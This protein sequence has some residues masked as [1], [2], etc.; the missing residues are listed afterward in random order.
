[1]VIALIVNL[2]SYDYKPIATILTINT[3]T[4]I[5][6]KASTVGFNYQ[7]Q[8]DQ[9]QLI[10]HHSF[11]RSLSY[12]TVVIQVIIIIIVRVALSYL[13]NY[14]QNNHHHHHPYLVHKKNHYN[15]NH[16]CRR[17]LDNQFYI[18]IDRC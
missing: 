9:L 17:C 7:S 3:I 18:L 15:P 2:P 11:I 16:L 1:M 10:G 5:T 6:F 12:Y 4:I 14:N 13:S 8:H